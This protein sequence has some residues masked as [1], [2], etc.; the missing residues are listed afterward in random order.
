MRRVSIIAALLTVFMLPGCGHSPTEE[1]SKKDES[2]STRNPK[3]VK[4][5]D[6]KPDKTQPVKIQG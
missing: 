6:F 5:G 2:G 1:S 4:D 3:S